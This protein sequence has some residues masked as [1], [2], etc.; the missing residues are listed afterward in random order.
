MLVYLDDIFLYFY[1]MA[2][3]RKLLH[4]VITLL[5]KYKLYT[6]ES[7][8]Y[9]FLKSVEFLGYVID[10]EVMHIENR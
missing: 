8:C 2:S 9:L 10:E 4:K 6:K 1:D 7:K 3:H 5:K